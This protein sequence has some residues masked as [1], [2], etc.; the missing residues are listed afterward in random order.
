M[1]QRLAADRLLP[2]TFDMLSAEVAR[3]CDADWA[4]R[5]DHGHGDRASACERVAILTGL[6]RKQAAIELERRSGVPAVRWS[7]TVNRREL[8]AMLERATSSNPEYLSQHTIIRIRVEVERPLTQRLAQ[9]ST[10]T[11]RA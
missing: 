5:W 2:F 3:Q 10:T 8:T 4:Q 7:P 1:T 6:S 9:N 11:T